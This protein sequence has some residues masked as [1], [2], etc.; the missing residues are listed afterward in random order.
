MRDA[1]N[2]GEP[3]DMTDHERARDADPTE[4]L[5][6]ALDSLGETVH[7]AVDAAPATARHVARDEA[8]ATARGWYRRAVLAAAVVAVLVATAASLGALWLASSSQQAVAEQ[9]AYNAATRKIAEDSKRTGDAANAE[10]SRRGQ[11]PVP[12][13]QPGTVPDTDVVVASATARVLAHLPDPTPTRAQLG[14]AVA[15]Y[16]SEH[17][18]APVGPTP[19][20]LSSS[21]AG[22]FA[23]HPPP[24]GKDGSD[25]ADGQP[26][27]DGADG[28]DGHTPTAEEIQAAF[29]AYV[30]DHP[31]ALCP[32]G[33]HYTELRVLLAD[34]GT[35][36][37]WQC[38]VSTAPPPTTTTTAPTTT[39]GPLLP[40]PTG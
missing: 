34:G 38:V 33:G 32:R 30:Q 29:V 39:D 2:N 18:V 31:D 14:Q 13:P 6:N 3:G 8:Q 40:L 12:I 26:G 28:Q 10:L 7:Q 24:A 9:A 23:V 5:N 27:Q 4:R 19:Q 25:G 36:D 17:P 1:G 20:Q 15:E 22:Y 21:I 37:T 11:A 35:A 16:M